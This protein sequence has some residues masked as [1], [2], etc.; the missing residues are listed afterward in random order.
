[1]KTLLCKK[2]EENGR[3]GNNKNQQQIRENEVR[4]A[5]KALHSTEV[6]PNSFA[7]IDVCPDGAIV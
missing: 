7:I 3:A 1:M 5:Q 6:A 2:A 4:E